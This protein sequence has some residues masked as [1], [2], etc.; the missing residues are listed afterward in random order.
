MEDK[1]FVGI[2]KN[3]DPSGLD[4][5]IQFGIKLYENKAALHYF[6]AISQDERNKI[7][8]YIDASESGND[9]IKRI[10]TAINNLNKRNQ[11]FF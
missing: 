6:A 1:V 4:M 10:N 3:P 7:I 9:T 8:K 2:G 11:N 5:P